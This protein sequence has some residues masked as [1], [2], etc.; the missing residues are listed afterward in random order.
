MVEHVHPINAEYLLDGAEFPIE[1]IGLINH[2]EQK[3]GRED[4]LELL[5]GLPEKRFH[6]I[7]EVNDYL[8]L[9]E[10][11]PMPA[12]QFSSIKEN[13]SEVE[14]ENE[15]IDKATATNKI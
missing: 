1:K 3:G 14:T 13:F 10:A 6:N 7:Q 8:G 15:A 12:N 5:R 2:A 9:I 11:L 4:A